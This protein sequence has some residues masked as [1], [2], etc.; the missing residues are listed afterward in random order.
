MVGLPGDTKEGFLYSVDQ[1][2]NLQPDTVRIHPVM[3]FRDTV[4]AEEF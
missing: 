1:T 4:L 2:I 3:V